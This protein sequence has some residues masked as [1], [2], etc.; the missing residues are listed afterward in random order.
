ML[1]LLT[2]VDSGFN[3]QESRFALEKLYIE[4]CFRENWTK[5]CF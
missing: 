5:V 2:S 4:L 1:V 3:F